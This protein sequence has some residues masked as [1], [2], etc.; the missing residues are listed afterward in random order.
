MSRKGPPHAELRF[1]PLNSCV[2]TTRPLRPSYRGMVPPRIVAQRSEV[3]YVCSMLG[4]SLWP[5]LASATDIERRTFKNN[6]SGRSPGHSCG[7]AG[8]QR[9]VS[10]ETLG[11]HKDR[12]TRRRVF[13][14][15]LS[16][17]VCILRTNAIQHNAHDWSC[18]AALTFELETVFGIRIDAPFVARPKAPTCSHQLSKSLPLRP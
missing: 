18:F 16:V 5:C 2:H 6:A 13:L 7:S 12:F 15:T 9:D 14:R 11:H 3:N 8:N 10:V 1:N 4:V 17:P